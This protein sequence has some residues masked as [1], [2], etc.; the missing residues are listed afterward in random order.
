MIKICLEFFLV[1]LW[2]RHVCPAP[3]S[4][5]EVK[6]TIMENLAVSADDKNITVVL[7]PPVIVP[8][9]S[10]PNE[11]LGLTPAPTS[12]TDVPHAPLAA[13]MF[14]G[15]VGTVNGSPVFLH[16]SAGTP[17]SSPK[18]IKDKDAQNINR[19]VMKAMEHLQNIGQQAQ[20]GQMVP[21]IQQSMDGAMSAV[22]RTVDATNTNSSIS[23]VVVPLVQNAFDLTEPGHTSV[24]QLAASHPIVLAN[25]DGNHTT[26]HVVVKREDVPSSLLPLADHNA[27]GPLRSSDLLGAAAITA[28]NITTTPPPKNDS[29]GVPLSNAHG[30]LSEADNPTPSPPTS[31]AAPLST[32]KILVLVNPDTNSSSSI[33]APTSV[34]ETVANDIIPI[35]TR[36]SSNESIPNMHSIELV[37]LVTQH[38]EPMESGSEILHAR[39]FVKTSDSAQ[40]SNLSILATSLVVASG[41]PIIHSSPEVRAGLLAQGTQPVHNPPEVDALT[42]TPDL[43]RLIASTLPSA[44]RVPLVVPQDSFPAKPLPPGTSSFL[45]VKG[46]NEN[47][48]SAMVRDLVA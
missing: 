5:V 17:T 8:A 19:S 2:T 43:Q 42:T 3:M 38:K 11:A 35:I 13:E 33:V 15:G 23:V 40:N 14:N 27:H 41:P 12:A 21:L 29:L 26:V 37:D 31:S 6:N 7:H 28:A 1:F 18:E 9:L 36:T 39:P 25:K 16:P 34:N 46:A 4:P 24:A 22:N 45:P 30:P 10:V 47:A 20:E 32:E 48:T 44:P